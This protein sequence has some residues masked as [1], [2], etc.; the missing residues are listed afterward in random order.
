MTTYVQAFNPLWYAVGLDGLAAG[1]AILYTFDGYNINT[2]KQVYQDASNTTP[3]PNPLIFKLN[4]TSP[5]PIYW[6]EESGTPTYY[7]YR[8]YDANGNLLQEAFN[9]PQYNSGGGSGGGSTTVV[10]S[11]V[12]YISNSQF[13]DRIPTPSTPLLSNILIAPSN[14]KGFTPAQAASVS[15]NLIGTYGILAPDIW[16]TKNNTSATDAIT[17]Q[18]FTLG[19]NALAPDITPVEYIEYTCTGA[20]TGESYKCFQFPIS[21]KIQT[22][23]EQPVSFGIWAKSTSGTPSIQLFTRQYYGSGT[24]ATVESGTTRQSPSGGTFALTTNWTWYPL[25]FTIPN[26][27]GGS[28]GQSGEQ[29]N[30]DALY[31][32]IQMPLNSTCGIDFTKPILVLGSIA[33]A[34]YFDTYDIIDSIDQT[35]RTGDIKTSY[36]ATTP[37]GWLPM[38]DSTIGNAASNA[39]YQGQYTFQLFCT[40]YTTVSNTYAPLNDSSGSPIA[41]TGSGNTMTDAITDFLANRQLTMPLALGRA[42]AVAGSGSGLTP[43]TLGQNS[44]VESITLSSAN[45]PSTVPTNSSGINTNRV[46]TVGSG[47]TFVPTNASNGFNGGSGNPFSNIQPTTYMNVFIKL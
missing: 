44:G 3:W 42:L 20:G 28:L 16:F 29:T 37:L 6:L 4:G 24:S 11:I 22:L 19:S 34:Q 33:P 18:E 36:L 47:G 21:Q 38:N 30:D 40:L 12:N 25:N 14:H 7:Y 32:Q 45:M 10:N 2:P 9:F 31:L 46:N 5:G 17:F 13:I 43:T 26:I 39:T 35:P 41:R 27:T 15:N 8:L 1:G 23:S